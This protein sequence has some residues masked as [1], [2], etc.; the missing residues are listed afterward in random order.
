MVA[1][2]YIFIVSSMAISILAVMWAVVDIEP[3]DYNGWFVRGFKYFKC[4][5]IKGHKYKDGRCVNCGKLEKKNEQI[6]KDR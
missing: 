3:D 2:A 5:A 4:G 6:R 1:G